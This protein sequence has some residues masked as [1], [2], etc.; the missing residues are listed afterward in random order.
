MFVQNVDG[1]LFF[2]KAKGTVK[3]Y[4]HLQLDTNVTSCSRQF[5]VSGVVAAACWSTVA[6]AGRTDGQTYGRG[7][8]DGKGL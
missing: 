5:D 1:V 4:V 8:G 3:T 6:A 2:V 7:V